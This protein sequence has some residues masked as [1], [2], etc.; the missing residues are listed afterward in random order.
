MVY[1]E[2]ADDSVWLKIGGAILNAII[3]VVAFVV[4]TLILVILY[5]YR[6][7]KIIFGWLIFSC[8]VLL[9]FM[10]WV[11]LELF[12]QS[13]GLPLDYFTYFFLLFNFALVGIVSIFWR[14][15]KTLT[16]AYLIMCSAM[17]AW[18]LTRLPEWTSWAM[19]AAVAIYDVIAVLTPKGPLNILVQTAQERGEPIPGL[20]YEGT[21]F[22]LGLGDFVF[23]SMLVGRASLY[24]FTTMAVC[25][26]C[27]LTVRLFCEK[28]RKCSVIF[29]VANSMPWFFLL[30]SCSLGSVYDTLYFGY[31]QKGTASTSNFHRAGYHFLLCN[32]LCH[33]SICA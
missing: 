6:C 1:Q 11:W 21:Q 30:P 33:T 28:Q 9:F 2:K 7:M 8:S 24:D 3:V 10:G 29:V 14:A 16:Q 27:V 20:I 25:F 23:Y 13:Y 15:H 12:L 31:F 4:I 19:L 22:K 32:A 17:T 26:V 5:K 18:W